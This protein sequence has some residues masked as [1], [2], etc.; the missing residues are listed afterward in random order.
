MKKKTAILLNLAILA[1]VIYA[2]G[3]MVIGVDTGKAL[4]AQ[5]LR[6][7]KYF[8]V[9]SN[10]LMAVSALI[11]AV[12]EIRSLGNGG[13][14]IP[15]WVYILKLTG[16][17]SVTLTLLTVLVFLGPLF[18][19]PSM[20]AGMNLHLHLTVPV[21]AILTF[22]LFERTG[23]LTFRHTLI[24]VIPMIVYGTFYLGNIL[25]NGRG[26]WPDTNDWYGFAMWGIP[27][28]FLVFVI[29]AAATW[30]FALILWKLNRIRK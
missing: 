7:L 20:F 10:I 19:C 11:A 18:G 13:R 5:R 14:E 25:L 17:T 9:D 8:T 21:L 28:S 15:G 30:V 12:F 2:W 16:T 6:S 3:G 22:C 1:L 4:T 27:A 24:A 29:I 26:E 23:G